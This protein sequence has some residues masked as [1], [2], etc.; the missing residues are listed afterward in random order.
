M[1]FAVA[2]VGDVDADGRLDVAV[3][4]PRH[5]GSTLPTGAL[6][7]FSDCKGSFAKVG[8]SCPGTNGLTPFLNVQGCAT[9]GGLVDLRLTVARANATALLLVGPGAAAVALGGSCVL[10]VASPVLAGAPFSTDSA[11]RASLAV[12]IPAG[13]PVGPLALQAFVQDAAAAPGFTATNGV[14]ITFE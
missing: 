8:A 1:G 2:G 14:V 9:S 10:H 11:G 5:L 7:V 3:G 13:V 4:S 12:P 6:T